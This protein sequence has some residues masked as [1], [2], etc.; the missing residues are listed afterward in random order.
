MEIYLKFQI[1]LP[2]ASILQDGGSDYSDG[3][4]IGEAIFQGTIAIPAVGGYVVNYAGLTKESFV[5]FSHQDSAGFTRSF[6]A[7]AAADQTEFKDLV[8]LLL[9]KITVP[10]PVAGGPAMIPLSAANN[11]L[12]TF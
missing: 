1:I 6:N 4:I 2:A 7:L 10:N 12:P 9:N 3:A 5:R 8:Q 11:N